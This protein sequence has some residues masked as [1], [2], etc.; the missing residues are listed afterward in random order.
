MITDLCQKTENNMIEALTLRQEDLNRQLATV[1]D[2]VRQ[3]EREIVQ[4]IEMNHDVIAILRSVIEEAPSKSKSLATLLVKSESDFDQS[5]S[6]LREAKAESDEWTGIHQFVN[7]TTWKHHP[8]GK[9][10]RVNKQI[11]GAQLSPDPSVTLL[12]YALHRLKAADLWEEITDDEDESSEDDDGS[13]GK[14]KNLLL[15]HLNYKEPN[16]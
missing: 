9:Q 12:N 1:R 10:Y 8:K 5:V 2:A 16:I 14:I 6:C 3:V 13:L 11:N 15:I 4:I 7:Q